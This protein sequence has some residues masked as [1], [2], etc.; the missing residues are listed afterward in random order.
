MRLLFLVFLLG[1]FSQANAQD[2][3]ARPV[4]FIA[5]QAPGTSPDITARFIAD[6]L[7]RFLGQPVVVENRPGGQKDRKSTRLNSSHG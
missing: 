4:K 7:S 3:P 5:S 1:I 6:R 2:W